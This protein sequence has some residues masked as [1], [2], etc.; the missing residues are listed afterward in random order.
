VSS[1]LIEITSSGDYIGQKVFEP[2]GISNRFVG[3]F[4]APWGDADVVSR[5]VV[6][7]VAINYFGIGLVLGAIWATSRRENNVPKNF[8]GF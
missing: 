1:N 7:N 3:G 4:T 5:E 8:L 6:G 2:V